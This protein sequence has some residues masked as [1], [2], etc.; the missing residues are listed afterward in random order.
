[1]RNAKAALVLTFVPIMLPASETRVRMNELPDAV[2][3]TVEEQIQNSS[4]KGFRK[5]IQNGKTYY[6]AETTLKGR[7]R[8]ILIDSGGAV[9]EVE[10][11]VSLDRIPNAARKALEVRASSGKILK[12]EAVTRGSMVSYE[13][14]ISRNGKKSE[15]AVDADG[16][17]RK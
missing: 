7:S 15:V 5:E 1:M 9:V 2:R 8:D 11:Q 12:V 14:V 6:E 3:K 4:V 10:E 17:I 13:A 16:V